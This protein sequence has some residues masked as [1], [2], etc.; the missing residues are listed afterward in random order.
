AKPAALVVRNAQLVAQQ[1]QRA[2]ELFVLY[3]NGQ[4]LSST[5]RIEPMLARVAENITLVMGADRCKIELI[6]QENPSTLYEAAS[7]SNDGNGE[8]ASAPT[9]FD[10][11]PLI[12]GLLRSG[13]VLVLGEHLHQANRDQEHQ[14]LEQL[15]YRSALV[16]ALK[17][18]DRT[19][20]LL[21]I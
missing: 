17:I 19:L 21:S 5:L 9:P 20:G 1:Q 7:Y 4:V 8:L 6:D 18:K 10:R 16:L 13:E 12:A 15:G 14:L 11:S 2:R 3:E